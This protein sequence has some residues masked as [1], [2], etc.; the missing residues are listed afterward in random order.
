MASTRRL[1]IRVINS[2]EPR[3]RRPEP[4]SDARGRPPPSAEA[5]ASA[6]K[7]VEATELKLAKLQAPPSPADVEAARLD[8]QKARNDLKVLRTGPSSTLKAAA[9]QAVSASQAKVNQV[10][11]SPIEIARLK[12]QAAQVR[13]NTARTAVDQL[14]VR[15]PVAGT[16]TSL[17]SAPGAPVDRTTP[18]ATV[19]PAC[20]NA[21]TRSR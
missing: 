4:Y 8:L 9:A 5:V 15:S 12:V 2:A 18:V 16:V 7:A 3:P 1:K 14:L 11:R 20:C 21:R 10:S 13:A 19:T 6:Q 17:L